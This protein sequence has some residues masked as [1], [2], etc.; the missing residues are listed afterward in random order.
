MINY[1]N[2]EIT[3]PTSYTIH[4]KRLALV[5]FNETTD[6]SVQRILSCPETMKYL[7]FMA[8]APEGWSHEE[9]VERRKNRER[10]NALGEDLSFA[11]AITV[12][13]LGSLVDKFSKEEILK[14]GTNGIDE[15]FVI[16]GHCGLKDIDLRSANAEVGIILDHRMWKGGYG[17]EAIYHCL[18]TSFDV[19][20]LHKVVFK[21][22]KDNIPMRKWLEKVAK[23][24]LEYVLSEVLVMDNHYIDSYEYAIYE[25]QWN[26]YLKKELV[27]WLELE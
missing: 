12:K 23:V 8:K 2:D 7:M 13:N 15:D 25:T 4:G 27:E 20:K 5:P 24:P 1:P 3:V 18:Q 16:I 14:A 9:V 26:S 10:L 22:T 17:S 19:L 21:T 11:I 6:A